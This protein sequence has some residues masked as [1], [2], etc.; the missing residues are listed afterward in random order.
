MAVLYP[1]PHEFTCMTEQTAPA[2]AGGRAPADDRVVALRERYVAAQL[3]GDRQEALRLIREEGLE[4]GLDAPRIALEV[5][6]PAQAEIG[7]LWQENRI[8]IAEEH[9]ATA[10]SQLVVSTLYS[11]FPRAASNGKRVIVACVEGE[12][13]EIGAR[14]AAD[15][16]EMAGF[17]VHFLGANVPTDSLV[18]MVRTELPHLV[19]LS[20]ATTL[21]LA[22]MRSAISRIR[23]VGGAALPIA[24]GGGVC[25][26]VQDLADIPGVSCTG[27]DVHDLVKTSRRL[28]G[29]A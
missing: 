24:V 14:L 2:A 28:T 10:I 22:A 29:V 20:S 27:T 3:A 23:L 9:L 1:R 16:L 12:Q 13:H 6:M 4:R 11:H 19:V 17:V 26:W 5:I 8:G 21:H 25:A 18:A 15:F 7:R